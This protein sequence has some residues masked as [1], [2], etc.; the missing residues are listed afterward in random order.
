[1]EENKPTD[2]A[3]VKVESSTDKT[4]NVT[5]RREYGGRSRGRGGGPGQRIRKKF[6]NAGGNKDVVQGHKRALGDD[7]SNNNHN[8]NFDEE[9]SFENYGRFRPKS[10]EQRLHERTMQLSGPTYEL[11]ANDL[12]EKKF[13]SRNRLYIGNT[14]GETT[15]NDL[16]ELF[17]PYGE[18][19]EMF[20]NKEK[21]FA[22]VK[23][24]YNCNARK[25]KKELDGS[26]LRSRNLKIRL[27][28][29]S[30][31]VKVKN[32]TPYVTNELLVYAFSIFG[33][34]E[35]A[36]VCVDERGKPSGEAIIDFSKKGSALQAIKTCSDDCFLLTSSLRPCIVEPFEYSDHNDGYSEKDI[37]KRNKDYQNERSTGPRFAA[38]GSVEEGFGIRWKELYSIHNQ[39]EYSLKKELKLEMEKLQAQIEYAKYEY[40]TEELRNKL[41]I[42][43]MN[44]EKQKREWEM[45]QRQFEEERQRTEENMKRSQEGIDARVYREQE[46]MRR[47]QDESKLYLQ[48]HNLDSILEMQEKGYEQ[49]SAE[50]SQAYEQGCSNPSNFSSAYIR[51]PSTI[52][53]PAENGGV[54]V[55][56]SSRQKRARFN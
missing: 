44:K 24:D 6:N 4:E 48:A 25:A 38:K 12:P 2:Q 17:K 40:E 50:L 36:V 11:P 42:R 14:S 35:R 28:P 45:K 10:L 46:D 26:T 3:F 55:T 16:E 19:A 52:R 29:V 34:V 43:E 1:M 15:E 8:Q 20:I 56:D 32:L 41:R 53:Y 7:L 9:A 51:P 31:S 47:M 21:N 22:F 13:N 27:A 30:S 5:N 37:Q 54:W 39:K 18:T 33:E 23:L 49:P